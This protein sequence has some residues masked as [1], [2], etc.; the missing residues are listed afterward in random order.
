M[1]KGGEVLSKKRATECKVI[2]FP[3]KSNPSFFFSKKFRSRGP[4]VGIY[5][6]LPDL[7]PP[8]KE[9]MLIHCSKFQEYSTPSCPSP[10][11]WEIIAL[12]SSN[13]NINDQVKHV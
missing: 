1:A 12:L 5:S 8:Y 9:Y 6:A 3:G 11:N 13:H 7:A 2:P 4:Q 10:Y